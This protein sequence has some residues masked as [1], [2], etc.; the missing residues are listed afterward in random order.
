MS[1][2]SS[3]RMLALSRSSSDKNTMQSPEGLLFGFVSPTKWAHTGREK[4]N[5]ENLSSTKS[6]TTEENSKHMKDRGERD[7]VPCALCWGQATVLSLR[8]E[9]WFSVPFLIT[10]L[11]GTCHPAHG[12]TSRDQTFLLIPQCLFLGIIFRDVGIKTRAQRSSIFA[13]S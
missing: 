1:Q 13:S 7:A 8:N 3:A 6:K 2:G 10:L 5:Q 12:L 11:N 4:R 9:W